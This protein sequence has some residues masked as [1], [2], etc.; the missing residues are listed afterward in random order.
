MLTEDAIDDLLQDTEF[1]PQGAGSWR[2]EYDTPDGEGLTLRLIHNLCRD[3]RT[4]DWDADFDDFDPL[5]D[6]RDQA[7][8][9]TVDWPADDQTLASELVKLVAYAGAHEA[10]E[11]I[12]IRGVLPADPHGAGQDVAVWTPPATIPTTVES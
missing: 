7:F 5:R 2:F 10:L 4:Y 1:A 9:L 8:Q 11:W 12:R 3:S 6:G